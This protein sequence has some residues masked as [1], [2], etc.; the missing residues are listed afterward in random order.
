MNKATK[1]E[2]ILFKKKYLNGYEKICLICNETITCLF[3]WQF[4]MSIVDRL[5]AG[6]DSL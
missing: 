5:F 6:E 1:L 2:S 3:F 4:P